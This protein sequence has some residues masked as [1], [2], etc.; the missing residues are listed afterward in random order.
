[1]QPQECST[2]AKSPGTEQQSV[3]TTLV[4]QEVPVAPE[5]MLAKVQALCRPSGV[6]AKAITDG[7]KA[8]IGEISRIEDV[9]RMERIIDGYKS[10]G[11]RAFCGRVFVG[12][13]QTDANIWN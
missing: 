8:I 1:M 11:V 9:S 6:T 3:C 7:A 5:T 12:A 13:I 10:N 4:H 2:T